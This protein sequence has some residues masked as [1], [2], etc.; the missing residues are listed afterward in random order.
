[1]LDLYRKRGSLK[2]YWEECKDFV[3]HL[4]T[5][6]EAVKKIAKG[7]FSFSLA[8]DVGKAVIQIIWMLTKGKAEQHRAELVVA[9]LEYI[10]EQEIVWDLPDPVWETL[11]WILERYLFVAQTMYGRD[12]EKNSPVTF[13]G[14]TVWGTNNHKTH[15]G[16]KKVK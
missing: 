15:K 7:E 4:Q 10:V 5:L 14:K 2:K 16:A 12:L 1:M 3:S 8:I 9:T 6:I 11:L 13:L